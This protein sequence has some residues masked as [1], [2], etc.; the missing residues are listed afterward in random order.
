MFNDLKAQMDDQMQR[1]IEANTKVRELSV[2]F[3]TTSTERNNAF[4]ND[5][6]QASME[7][8][9]SLVACATPSQVWD[10]QVALASKLREGVEGYMKTSFDAVTD[11]SQ[12]VAEL[13]GSVA[14]PVVAEKAAPVAAKKATPVAAK[15]AAPVDAEKAAP[16]DAE[17]A[18]PAPAPRRKAAAKAS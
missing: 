16:V 18:A 6:I 1:G 5:L 11:Y 14:A 15:K 10:T 12:T 8:A 3:A 13:T 9:Q 7:S 4:L 2:Q 17:K